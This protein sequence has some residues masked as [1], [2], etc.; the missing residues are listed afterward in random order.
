MAW[1]RPRTTWPS[2]APTLTMLDARVRFGVQPITRQLSRPHSHTYRKQP[3][4]KAAL[5]RQAAEI[6]AFALLSPRVVL[7]HRASDCGLGR[8]ERAVARHLAFQMARSVVRPGEQSRHGR[9]APACHK[10]GFATCPM[11]HFSP[12]PAAT[13]T[14]F[15]W[16]ARQMPCPLVIPPASYRALGLTSLEQVGPR[17]Q[18]P[19]S[20]V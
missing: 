19:A 11:F 4:M 20:P 15:M 13:A 9:P 18:L 2:E 12:R 7:R 5:Q 6:W 8:A 1:P 10:M 17:L 16:F 14:A 3:G